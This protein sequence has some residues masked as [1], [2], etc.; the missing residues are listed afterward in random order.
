MS[1]NAAIRASW[2]EDTTQPYLACED[3]HGDAVPPGAGNACAQVGGT[4]PTGGHHS[5][6]ALTLR[7]VVA[8]SCVHN[9]AAED[10]CVC[11]MCGRQE[12][13]REREHMQ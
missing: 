6:Q 9:A 5:T 13:E 11:G 2:H 12:R 8:L 4:W 1:N 3:D 7:L 10:I